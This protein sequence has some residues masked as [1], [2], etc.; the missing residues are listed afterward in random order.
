INPDDERPTKFNAEV[1]ATIQ[2]G[3]RQE[4]AK[5]TEERK[6][7][8]AALELQVDTMGKL[9]AL[10]RGRSEKKAKEAGE[11]RGLIELRSKLGNVEM[12]DLSEEEQQYGAVKGGGCVGE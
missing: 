2:A 3:A 8:D 4:G 7:E 10:E 9:A 5:T 12:K 6:R 11:L 1:Q